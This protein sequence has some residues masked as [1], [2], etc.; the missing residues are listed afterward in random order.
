MAAALSRDDLSFLLY[1]WLNVTELTKLTR[2][3]EHS[4]ETFDDALELSERI[5]TKRFAPLYKQLDRE[6]PSIADDGTVTLPSG[7]AVALREFYQAGLAACRF[8]ESLGGAQLPNTVTYAAMAWFQAS[9]IAISTYALLSV[10]AASL[11]KAHASTEQIDAYVRPLLTGQYFG[12]MCLS[13]PGAGSSLAD[14]STKAVPC[15]DGTYRITG[16][17]TWISGGDHELADNIVHL[18][19]ARTPGA[20]AGVK[21]ISLFIVPKVLPSSQRNDVALVGLNHKMGYRGTTNAVLSFGDGSFTTDLSPGAV[22]Y[23]VGEQFHGLKYMFDMMNEA[24]LG[25][26]MGATAL[27]YAAYLRTVEYAT[28]RTQGRA[29]GDRDVSSKPV[30][31]IEHPD[32]RRM[33]LAQKSYV[34]GALALVL[35]CANLLDKQTAGSDPGTAHEATMLLNLL[36][37][38]AKSWPSQWCLEANSL[39]IQVHGGYGYTREYDVEQ[40][41]RD[42]RLNSI[43]EGTNGIQ[44]LDLLGRKILMDGGVAL[45]L[46]DRE[47]NSTITHAL[48]TGGVAADHAAELDFAWGRLREVTAAI[49]DPEG[50]L[51]ALANATP[52]MHAFGHIVLAWIWLEQQLAATGTSKLHRGKHAAAG[53]FFRVELPKVQ[54]LLDLVE[55]GDRTVLDTPPDVF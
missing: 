2:F 12:T 43:H 14:L 21:G 4:K 31:I 20:P 28:V 45:N 32:V 55:R 16:T 36:T 39:A 33:V 24:R 30:A 19:L 9:N 3:E 42:N 41:Y 1:D 52:Y 25:V 15:S 7:V 54:A 38:V 10:A 50:V 40:Q 8:D 6:E 44:A 11:L 37:P 29:L 53:Y 17:K 46:L 13:E 26:G 49:T 34:E 35:Y 18:V 51:C 27:G 22:G 48:I 5:A 47:I 23:L